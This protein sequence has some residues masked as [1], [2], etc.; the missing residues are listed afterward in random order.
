MSI[1]I[2][3]RLLSEKLFPNVKYKVIVMHNASY[4]LQKK[5]IEHVIS[6]LIIINAGH[7][8]SDAYVGADLLFFNFL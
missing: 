5:C 8:F 2:C 7:E 6:D 4:Q 1:D 3:A